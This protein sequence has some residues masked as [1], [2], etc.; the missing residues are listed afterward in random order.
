MPSFFYI[1]PLK[2]CQNFKLGIS[3]GTKQNLLN[4]FNSHKAGFKSE[5]IEIDTKA[6]EYIEFKN[7]SAALFIEQEVKRA[8]SCNRICTYGSSEIFN[9]EHLPE[10]KK[11][12]S[13]FSINYGGNNFKAH[14]LGHEKKKNTQKTLKGRKTKDSQAVKHKKWTPLKSVRMCLTKAHEPGHTTQS[15]ILF[16]IRLTY[17]FKD[18]SKRISYIDPNTDTYRYYYGS[19][20]NYGSYSEVQTI[21]N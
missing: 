4:R 13:E 3:R 2:D 12:V 14:A 7:N 16:G 1:V 9:M 10:I 19:N 20:L 21:N 18:G 5:G 17:T 15:V 6:I 11:K 8:Y